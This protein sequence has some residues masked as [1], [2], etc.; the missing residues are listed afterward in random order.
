MEIDKIINSIKNHLLSIELS[1]DGE[2]KKNHLIVIK[3]E[4]EN[5]SVEYQKLKETHDTIISQLK[6]EISRLNRL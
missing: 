6:Q 5:L 4:V 1:S 2:D 3:Q